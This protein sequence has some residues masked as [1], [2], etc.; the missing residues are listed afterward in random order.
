[1]ELYWVGGSTLAP[2]GQSESAPKT[3]MPLLL[4]IALGAIVFA[5][6]LPFFR[7]NNVPLYSKSYSIHSA[8]VALFDNQHYGLAVFLIIFTCVTP[9][10]VLILIGHCW[11]V[12]KT[13]YQIARRL[14]LIRI[15]GEWSMLS[16]FLMALGITVTEG[17]MMVRTQ[18]KDGLWAIII[19]I[20]CS[21]ICT[22]LAY[23]KLSSMLVMTGDDLKT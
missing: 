19:A 4:L 15:V 3:T 12:R 18:I 23:R 14:D 20:L 16:V 13:H 10:L 17:E 2:I 22:R 5:I 1:M 21:V 6:E 9:I 11:M 7:I 8:I